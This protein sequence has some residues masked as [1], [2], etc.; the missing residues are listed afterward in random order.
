L[1]HIARIELEIKSLEDLKA[2]CNEL[3]LKFNENEQSYKWYGRWV[4]DAPLPEGIKEEDLGKCDHC[5]H[6]PGAQYQI[7][8]IK[9]DGKYRLLWDSWKAGGLEDVLGRN[10]G[11]LKQAYAVATIIRESRL[12]RLKV[13]Q[14]IKEKSIRIV[15]TV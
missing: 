15:L 5:I 1:S 8:V 12:K 9:Q 4:G 13:H 14:Q 11:L 6:V 2:A 3:G 10:A 7:G